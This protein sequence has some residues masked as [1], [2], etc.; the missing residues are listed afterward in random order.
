MLVKARCAQKFAQEPTLTI[1]LSHLTHLGP[2]LARFLVELA[3][4][5]QAAPVPLAEWREAVL[6]TCEGRSRSYRNRMAQAMRET[7]ALAGSGASTTA[8]GPE[9]IARLAA[10][11][12]AGATTNGLLGALKTACK[13]A[14]VRGWVLPGS[15]DRIA[16]RGISGHQTRSQHHSRE[17]IARVLGFLEGNRGSWEGGR[18]HALACTYAYTGLRLREALRLEVADLDLERGF[19]F[20]RP[21]SDLK[22]EQS[23]APV[24]CPRVLVEILAGWIPR[25]EARWVFPN[26]GRTGPW[27]GGTYGKRPTD[28]ITAAGLAAGV[29]GFT[30]LSLRHSLATHYAS[31]WGLSA[32]QIQQVL[33]HSTVFTQRHYVHIDLVNLEELVRYFDFD[34]DPPRRR[35]RSRRKRHRPGLRR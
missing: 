33:R 27:T 9:L 1:P 23:A 24:P 3:R 29:P 13:L 14:A 17:A 26:V 34:G 2:E 28:R 20:V 6:A 10:R 15:L 25:A 8:L 30:P 19:V 21:G 4:A 18:L 16:W 31:Y 22:T 12:G 35:I 32:K 11:P 5:A 7:I